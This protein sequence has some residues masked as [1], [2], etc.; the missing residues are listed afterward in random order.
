MLKIL[1]IGNG[2]REHAIVWKLSQSSKVPKIYCTK[3]NAG[4]LELAENVDIAP[5]NTCKLLEFAIKEKIDLTIVGPELPL[6]LGIVDVFE[7]KG[8]RIFG[9]SKDAAR[10]ESSKVFMKNLLWDN[11]LATAVYDVCCMSKSDLILHTEIYKYPIVIKKDGLTGGKGV[12]ICKTKFDAYNAINSIYAEDNKPKIIIEDFLEGEELSFMVVTDGKCVRALT[13][14][15]DYKKAYNGDKGPNT[16]G[17]G[18]VS[19]APNYSN[20]LEHKIMREVIIPVLRIMEFEGTPFKGI[21]YAGL[22]I[23]GDDV[24]VLEFNCRFGDPEAQAILMR[25]ENDLVDVIE[26]AV[27]GNLN[28]VDLKWKDDISVCVVMAANGYPG[29]YEKGVQVIA[30]STFYK[31]SGIKIFHAGTSIEKSGQVVS[32]GG[33][34]LGVTALGKNIDT[35]RLKAFQIVNLAYF[36]DVHYRTDIGD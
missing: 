35:A 30:P 5:T 11:G 3:G 15:K 14:S 21:L 7:S 20:E 8:L 26:A 33:R 10:I 13:T 28:N 32:N 16:G 23:N 19:P 18:A 24:K 2:G 22:M 27:D 9:P 6:S 1:V 12:Y 31:Y 4:M 34:V 17:M 36:K 25:L 29:N